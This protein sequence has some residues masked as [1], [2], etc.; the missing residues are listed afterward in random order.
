MEIY[1]QYSSLLAY[2]SKFFPQT[3]TVQQ[4]T[5]PTSHIHL[6]VVL[7][8]LSNKPMLTVTDASISVNSATSSVSDLDRLQ[9]EI[10]SE[11]CF[12]LGQNLGGAGGAGGYSA[13]GAGGFDVAGAA[14]RSVDSNNDGS[15]DRGEF[16]RFFQQGL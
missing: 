14:F 9:R 11:Q 6:V 10:R 13:G 3:K 12:L 5:W 2:T 4:A 8:R 1:Q 16:N 15:I 7:I